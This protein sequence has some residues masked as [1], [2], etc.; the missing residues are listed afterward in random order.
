MLKRAATWLCPT[1]WYLLKFSRVQRV[2]MTVAINS[3][4]TNKFL[5]SK[6]TCWLIPN[7]RTSKS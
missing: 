4:F 7:A 6:N 1:R 2:R 3:N 5:R